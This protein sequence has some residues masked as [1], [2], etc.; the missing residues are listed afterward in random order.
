M[1]EELQ[2][3]I[4]HGIERLDADSSLKLQR[5]LGCKFGGVDVKP[6][7]VGPHLTAKC[8]SLLFEALR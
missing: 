7:V 5:W 1:L 2:E 8:R 6:V 4:D 3:S